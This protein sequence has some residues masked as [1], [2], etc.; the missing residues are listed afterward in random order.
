[1]T[2]E[3]IPKYVNL[4]EKDTCTVCQDIISPTL[5][6]SITILTC[7]HFFHKKMYKPL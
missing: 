1:N 6:E 4:E 3:E 7:Q 2:F 5:Q